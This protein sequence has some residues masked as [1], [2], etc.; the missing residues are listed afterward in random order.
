MSRHEQ[1]ARTILLAETLA[2]KRVYIRHCHALV[3]FDLLV[4]EFRILEIRC[5]KGESLRP[6]AR[7]LHRGDELGLHE[8]NRASHLFFRY[9]IAYQQ[10]D[11]VGNLALERLWS[12][13]GTGGDVDDEQV[14]AL[15]EVV[16]KCLSLRRDLTVAYEPAIEA[17]PLAQAE[18]RRADTRRVVLLRAEDRRTEREKKTGQHDLVLDDDALPAAER[19]RQRHVCKRWLP[20][21]RRDRPEV[22]RYQRTRLDA[23][24][25]SRYRQHRVV[26]RVV[27]RE[28][29]LDVFEARRIEIRHRSDERMVKWVLLGKSQ[30][31][32]PLPPGPVGLIVDRPASLVLHDV[33]LGVQLL[34][35]HRR[36]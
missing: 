6:I 23:V 36:E 24:E 18:N 1:K 15:G 32:Q 17:A 25:V 33:A 5:E 11:F 3:L 21:P 34:L 22:L 27:G 13:R 30:R 2:G 9:A 31:G 35:R 14:S 28:E 12:Q 26:R 4:H 20:A 29:V 10:V 7:G 8:R 19:C 16:R